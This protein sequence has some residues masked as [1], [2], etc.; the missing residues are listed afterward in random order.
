MLTINIGWEYVL[1]ILGTLVVL[2]YYAN[3]RVTRLEANFDWLLQAVR[4]LSIRLEN[5]S[6]KAFE[7]G[8]PISLTATGEQL[9]RDSGLKSYVDRRR[10]EFLLL[11]KVQVPLDPYAIQQSAFRLF[12]RVPLDGPFTR[13]LNRYAFRN[14]ISV[15]L[16]RRVGAVYLRDITVR[17]N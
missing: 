8:S 10:D 15:D 11:L 16:L 5:A 6:R 9:L 12:D 2:A 4:D 13:Q 1:G 3:G 7:I 17:P 14:G